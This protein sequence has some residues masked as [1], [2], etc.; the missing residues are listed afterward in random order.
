M[1]ILRYVKWAEGKVREANKEGCVEENEILI[2]NEKNGY[3]FSIFNLPAYLCSI[4][5][6]NIY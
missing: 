5:L 2:L 3:I 4:I 6:T 1:H